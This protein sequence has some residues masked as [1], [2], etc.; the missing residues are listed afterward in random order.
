MGLYTWDDSANTGTLVARTANDTALFAVQTTSYAKSFD[1]TGGYPASYSLVAGTKYAIGFIVVGT[2]PPTISGITA[3][4]AIIILPPVISR[5][6]NTQTDLPT[7]AN[8][9]FPNNAGAM[10]FGRLT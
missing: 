1:T 9:P 2:T 7:A 8:T 5:A 3:N 4:N 10:Y 6:L